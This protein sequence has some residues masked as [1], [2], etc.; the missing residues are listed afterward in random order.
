V[1]HPKVGGHAAPHKFAD[2][3]VVFV[4]VVAG[5][6]NKVAAYADVLSRRV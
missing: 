6:S 1:D 5:A 3:R 2:D 4:D